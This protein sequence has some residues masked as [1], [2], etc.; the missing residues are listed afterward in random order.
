MDK[1][2]IEAVR[3]RAIVVRNAAITFG[4]V[5]QIDLA[6][7]VADDLDA[8][9][10]RLAEVERERDE[11]REMHRV[12]VEEPEGLRWYMDRASERATRITAL[13]AEVARLTK[14][15][16][17]ARAEVDELKIDF[18]GACD[19]AKMNNDLAKMYRAQANEF[20]LKYAIASG[21][22]A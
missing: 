16:D 21:D 5:E 13:E 4:G 14:E 8:L 15:R 19:L 17:Q 20:R 12:W 3:V 22:P 11:A 7:T 2:E 10:T 9:A 6:K 1:E 18:A